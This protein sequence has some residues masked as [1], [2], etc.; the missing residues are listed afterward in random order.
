MHLAVVKAKMKWKQKNTAKYYKWLAKNFLQ[1]IT[2]SCEV[3]RR[4]WLRTLD[5]LGTSSVGIK[6]RLSENRLASR[7]WFSANFLC[8]SQASSQMRVLLIMS[9]AAAG[10]HW[11]YLI[12]YSDSKSI[13]VRWKCYQVRSSPSRVESSGD[14]NTHTEGLRII[15]LRIAVRCLLWLVS[16]ISSKRIMEL[17][18]GLA[19]FFRAK[20]KGNLYKIIMKNLISNL[21]CEI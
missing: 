10:Y 13:W 11:I 12:A 14:K 8:S 1:L 15:Y 20:K 7:R 2:L 3:R 6:A 17:D 5:G 4:R 21:F 16:E 18:C 9:N 19:Y